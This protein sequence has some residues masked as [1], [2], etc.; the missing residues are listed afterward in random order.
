M[1]RVL[2][3]L[4]ILFP[5]AAAEYRAPAGNF[6][7]IRRPGAAGI[8]PGGRIIA[9]FGLQYITGPGPWGL[10]VSPNG[11]YI[12]TADGG[13]QIFSLTVIERS[14][15]RYQTPRHLEASPVG[16][17]SEDKDAWRSVSGGLA[18]D[19]NRT[20]YV[21]EGNS[22]RIRYMSVDDT[23]AK[24]IIHLND[25]HYK[26]SYSGDLAYDATRNLLVAVDQANFRLVLIDAK[27]NRVLSSV[28]VGR[29]PFAVT[30]STDGK[31]AFVTNPG[32]FEYQSL[33]GA[34]RSDAWGTGLPFPAFGFHSPAAEGGVSRK[35]AIGPVE[36]PGLGRPNAP[37]SNSLCVV[38]LQNPRAPKV[39]AFIPTGKRYGAGASGGSSPVGVLVAGGRVFVSNAHNDSIT[40]VDGKTLRVEREIE[41]RIPGLENLR[42]VLP[43]GMA[44]CSARN[45]LLVAEAGI[46]AVGV[47]DPA[48]GKVIG[49]VP[50]SW[51]PTKVAVDG[52]TVYVTNAK[53]QGTGPNGDL[54][55]AFPEAFQTEM[56]RGSLS[57]FALPSAGDLELHTRRVMDANGLRPSRVRP[58]GIPPGIQNV[59]LIVKE[60]RTFDEIF[61]DVETASNGAVNG[62]PTLARF[63]RYGVV[64]APRG[65]LRSRLS[66]RNVN[67]TPN[68]HEIA[69]RWTM[70]DNFY[71]DSEV[72]LE[73]HHWLSGAYPDALVQSSWIAGYGGERDFRQPT[74]APG[75]LSFAQRNCSVH[76]EEL[77]EAGALWHHLDRFGISFRSFGE[78]FDLAGAEKRSGMKPTGARYLTNM[79]MPEPLYRNT[80]RQY[81]Q[82]NMN[83]PDQYRAGQFIAEMKALYLD[84]GKP[85]PRLLYILLPNDHAAPPR[86]GDGY[87][88]EA[89]YVADNDFALGRILQFLSNTP[90]WKQMAVFITEANARGGVDHVDS[91]RTAMM[92][93]SPYA[94]KNYVSHI[95]SSF[96]GLLKTIFRILGLP[97]LNLF[98]AVASDLADCFTYEPDYEPYRLQTVTPELFDPNKAREGAN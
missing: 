97:P 18:F 80:S 61:G 3:I 95:H 47:I 78:G 45:W 82:F 7:V 38:N 37:E 23:A 9:P 90:W 27:K 59:V 34:D 12:V 58:Q 6:P 67:V 93:A 70:S 24:R 96:P 72:S 85:F 32:I 51:F 25:E 64:Y 55:R 83:I 91:H 57:V 21:S 44:Y 43:I 20:L 98:D 46:N 41:I 84:A 29:L 65:Q 56:R 62:A 48:A 4:V 54:Q 35:R 77:P 88:Y 68:Q 13:P 52:E 33:P 87:P 75:R 22:G 15:E 11:K 39:E 66:L 10:A 8:I 14:K 71:A 30:L 2:P 73:G 31:R 60:G 74:S 17:N 86:A 49:H 16:E 50:V 69:R 79:P 92:I 94:R 53:G 40:V 76:P 19:G 63:G 81:P 26:D 1:R 36:V 5:L 89:S 42:G 28:K